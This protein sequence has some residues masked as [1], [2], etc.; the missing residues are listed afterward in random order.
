[1]A[2]SC[3]RSASG[4]TVFSSQ[5]FRS[6]NDG[7][8]SASSCSL[9]TVSTHLMRS[10]RHFY[11]GSPI[12]RRLTAGA[13]RTEW[14]SLRETIRAAPCRSHSPVRPCSSRGDPRV[15]QVG[16]GSFNLVHRATAQLFREP[17]ISTSRTI[18]SA[19]APNFAQ[20]CS[21]LSKREIAKRDGDVTISAPKGNDV[22]H[23]RDAWLFCCAA[24]GGDP[25]SSG[26]CQSRH[27]D[28][29]RPSPPVI[30]FIDINAMS[31]LGVSDLE[32]LSP[33]GGLSALESRFPRA[34]PSAARDGSLRRGAT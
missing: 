8:L 27:R 17:E 23:A 30:R 34:A 12:S 13:Q 9:C 33:N 25:A 28:A 18:R 29:L 3:M 11:R 2:R 7:R 16:I 4:S 5:S 26:E 31:D 1:M 19:A 22:N 6:W 32:R 14:R 21:E 15:E 10:R 20:F 24:W